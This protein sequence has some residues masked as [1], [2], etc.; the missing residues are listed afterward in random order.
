MKTKIYL[1]TSFIFLLF[2]FASCSL[3]RAIEKSEKE[4]PVWVYGITNDYII[5]EGVGNDFEEA[6]NDVL[7]KLKERIVSSVAV[8]ISSET[9]IAINETVIDNMSRYRENT[10]LRTNIS[11]DFF[12]SLRGISLSKSKAYYWEKQKHPDKTIKVHYHVMYPFSDTEL[13][14]LI[15]EWE[16]TDKSFT[17]ELDNL[18]K[19]VDDC[20]SV[21][22]L[23]I[24]YEKANELEKIFTGM[25]KTR[26][27]II[28]TE[29]NQLI[30]NLRFEVQTHEQG[31]LIL[32]LLS[33]DRYFNM[34]SDI[35]FK[36]DCAVLQDR[37][38][39]ND[40][41]ALEINYDADFC[42]TFEKS[43]FQILQNYEGQVIQS[44]FLIPDGENTVRFT[45]NEPVRFRKSSTNPQNIKWYIPIR[46]FTENEFTVTR[47]ELVVSQQS[48]L[49]LRK[50]IGGD[51]KESFYITDINQKFSTKG[52][53]SLQ[54]EVG[55][56][57]NGPKSLLGHL[58]NVFMTESTSYFAGG[59]IFIKPSSGDKEL[60]FIFENKKI[61]RSN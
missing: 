42:Y 14:T 27:A 10:E 57:E 53:F 3:P 32:K 12:N 17:V 31:R 61:I 37:K 5:I 11:T 33:S 36:S 50:F 39:V 29:I 8:N 34:S 26:A 20:N 48:N 40:N 45:I 58:I 24:L 15:K 49:D 9:N 47:V 16:K 55:A 21:S 19:S 4:R 7:K 54:F 23:Q 30:N 35:D 41:Q 22:E 46:V 1:I 28:K 60:V 56:T 44:Q 38:L 51:E 59:K 13:N 43:N 2:V 52:D 18:E 6:R 25:R